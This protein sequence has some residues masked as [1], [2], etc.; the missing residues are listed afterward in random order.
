MSPIDESECQLAIPGL[1]NVTNVLGALAAI[2][3]YAELKELDEI[4]ILTQVVKNLPQFV[5]AERRFEVKGEAAGVTVV[6]DYAHHPTEVRATLAGARA[7]YPTHRIVALF[8]PHTYSRTR[9]LLHDFA[10]SFD[11]ADALAL[12]PIFAAREVNT[13]GVSSEDVIEAIKSS[14][15]S[16]VV[17]RPLPQDKPQLISPDG[18]GC[19]AGGRDLDRVPTAGRRATNAR[20]G[21]RV[22]GRRGG[23]GTLKR[24]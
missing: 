4:Q 7:R 20:R 5:G 12:M 6:D 3:V 10:A 19:G 16:K 11:D 8:Q 24:T 18:A 21:R 22:A 15:K 23:A 14:I 2:E 1:H 9:G 17:G 13:D